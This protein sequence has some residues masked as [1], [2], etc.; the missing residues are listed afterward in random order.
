MAVAAAT[1]TLLPPCAA[2]VALKTLTATAMAE[3]QTIN[4]EP[5]AALATATEIA[6]MTTLETKGVLAVAELQHQRGV[7]GQLGS[8]CLFSEKKLF[9]L[10]KTAVKKSTVCPI[11]SCQNPKCMFLF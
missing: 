10:Q 2:A 11:F 8:G 6:T 3:A 5:K 1:T 9:D 4:N 7:S